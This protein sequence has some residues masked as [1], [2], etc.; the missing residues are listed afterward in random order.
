MARNSYYKNCGPSILRHNTKSYASS[1]SSKKETANKRYPPLKML[2]QSGVEMLNLLAEGKSIESISQILSEKYGATI[3]LVAS[4]VQI[5]VHS[6]E[7]KGL[8]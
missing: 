4:D 7:E 6:I 5:F 8:L 2:N 1:S 3:D